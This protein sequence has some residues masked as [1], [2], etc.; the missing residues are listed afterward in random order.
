MA[1]VPE[2]PMAMEVEDLTV[3]QGEIMEHQEVK[4][5]L[6]IVV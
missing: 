5:I 1:V 4:I 3:R 2:M 6:Q